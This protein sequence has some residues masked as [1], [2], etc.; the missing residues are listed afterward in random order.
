[1]A[2]AEATRGRQLRLEIA[3]AVSLCALTVVVFL[4][5]LDHAWLNY[6]DDIYITNN[7]DL[8]R[9]LT[10]NGVAWAFSSFHGAN[11]FPLTQLSWML[12]YEIYGLDPAGFHATNLALH[13]LNSLLLLTL[14]AHLQTMEGRKV[15]PARRNELR[16]VRIRERLGLN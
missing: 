8:L 1:M 13:A 3:L 4:P 12:D 10:R 14:P 15:G 5:M 2:V 7:P 9:G 6:D 11:W 16:A